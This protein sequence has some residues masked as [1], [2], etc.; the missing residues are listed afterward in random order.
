AEVSLAVVLLVSS[1]LLVR[2]FLNLRNADF[3]WDES[4]ILTFHVDL[5]QQVYQDNLRITTFFTG[6]MQKLASLPGVVSVGGTSLLPT[7]GDSHQV[8][9]VVGEETALPEESLVARYRLILPGYFHTLRIR[10][11]SG[12][13]FDSRDGAESERVAIV[14]QAF[15]L[16]HWRDGNALNEQI[17]VGE[18]VYRV[19]GVVSNTLDWDRRSEP[20]VYLSVLQMPR[21]HMTLVMRT[22]GPPASYGAQTRATL[23]EIDPNLPLFLL[24]TMEEVVQDERVGESAMARLMSILAGVALFL[25]VVGIYG[26]IA[27]SVSRRNR[28][29]G[30]R[31]AVGA[32]KNEVVRLVTIQGMKPAVFGMILGLVL[33]VVAARLLSAFLFGVSY[34]DPITFVGVAATILAAS[35]I[36]TFL[37]A[38]H[39]SRVDPIQM[40]RQ[41]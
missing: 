9:E 16:R 39:A 4:G 31:M 26:V 13:L 7:R 36:A 18:E 19:V 35:L 33:A 14:N 3:G 2:G 17:R 27:Y 8:Y 24:R 29:F 34:R 11:L 25:S 41:E 5:P 21:A 23:A 30:I 15:S 40:L 10:H 22:L 1:V 38:L 12:R 32:T 37:P 28:E 20:T 6:A